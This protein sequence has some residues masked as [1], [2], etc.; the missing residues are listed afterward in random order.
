MPDREKVIKGLETC[1][2]YGYTCMECP[3]YDPEDDGGCHAEELLYD[4]IALLKEKKP[5]GEW[6]RVSSDDDYENVWECSMCHT[7]QMII[8][9]TPEENEWHYCPH[10]GAKMTMRGGA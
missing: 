8:D 5:I 10:C 6:V 9:G 4:A 7:L 1:N 3:Y 2:C